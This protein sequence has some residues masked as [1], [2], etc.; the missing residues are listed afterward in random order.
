VSPTLATAQTFSTGA[1]ALDGSNVENVGTVFEAV[2]I[3]AFD[4][5]YSSPLILNGV[6]FTYVAGV[7]D[8]TTGTDSGRAGKDTR[9]RLPN[10]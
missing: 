1:L 5:E 4:G 3:V 7:N 8:G 10:L 6:T 2:D 9:S